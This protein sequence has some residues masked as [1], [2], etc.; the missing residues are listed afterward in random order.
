MPNFQKASD[1]YTTFYQLYKT[2]SDLDL[3]VE[4]GKLVKDLQGVF[5]QMKPVG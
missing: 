4:L 2:K 1:R 5:D 3:D